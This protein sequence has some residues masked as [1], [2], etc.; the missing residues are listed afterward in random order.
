M[1]YKIFNGFA[2]HQPRANPEDTCAEPSLGNR[3]VEDT[4]A[5]HRAFFTP[6]VIIHNQD[7]ID[8]VG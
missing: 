1:C 4:T 7:D 2:D 8:V 5:L 3:M 6:E